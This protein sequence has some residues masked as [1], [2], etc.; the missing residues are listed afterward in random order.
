MVYLEGL[1]CE[2][3][4]DFLLECPMEVDLGLSLCDHSRDA[5]IRCFGSLHKLFQ[6]ICRHC[7]GMIQS[8][9]IQNG[10][11]TCPRVTNYAASIMCHSVCTLTYG[12]ISMR[13]TNGFGTGLE[14]L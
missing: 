10:L 13:G 6:S 12:R 9:H 4:E 11:L 14:C 2:G 7:V 8:K 1:E 5:G 3:D